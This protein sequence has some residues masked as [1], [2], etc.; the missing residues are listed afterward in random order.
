MKQAPSR[1]PDG[2]LL[3]AVVALVVLGA[4]MVYS[5]SFVVAHNEF[6]DDTYF[7]VRQL[8]FAGVGGLALLAALRLDYHRWQ[9]LSLVL[10]LVSL[11]TLVAVLLPG[12]G[13]TTYGAQRWL[14]LGPVP[15]VQPSE[16]AK[17]ALVLY[18][19]DWLSR[20]G[21]QVRHLTFGLV[22]FA[23]IV[24]LVAGLVMLEPDLGT[25]VLLAITAV[26]IFFVA[27]ANLLHFLLGLGAGS[28]ALYW[29][30]HSA[31]YRSERLRVFLDPWKDP[32]DSGW[33]TIQ[34]LIA[35]G[36]GGLTGLGLGM[37]RQK[38]YWVPNAHTDAIFAIIGEELGLLGTVAVLA[39]F[40]LIAWRGMRIAF[41][42]P[43]LFGRLLATGFTSVIVWQ[44]LVNIAVVTNTV[45]YT[46]VPLPFVSHGGS[47]IVISMLAAGVLLNV[48]R[49][50]GDVPALDLA[51]A[52]S[53]RAG[54]A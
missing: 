28:V 20:K 26:S 50:L 14:K 45:P 35:L 11:A 4:L 19:A 7:L 30:I 47:S 12:L 6:D 34:T 1:A 46:G 8:L 38:A 3:G 44:A 49:F 24:A 33:H 31:G 51:P 18:L 29:M 5:A 48:S 27:G 2:L 17:F 22:P 10:L 36:S 53:W 39:L 40:A 15:P 9:A 23:I 54:H 16:F 13:I 43:D 42:A 25:T 21:A 52:G 32:Q 41:L 37:G